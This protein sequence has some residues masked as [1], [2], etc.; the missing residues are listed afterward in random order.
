MPN[1]L[2]IESFGLTFVGESVLYALLLACLVGGCVCIGCAW[3]LRICAESL[4][5][6]L[7]LV[8]ML[9]V[10]RALFVLHSDFQ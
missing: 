8:H 3:A 5:R 1:P 6:D 10:D 2:Y 9:G 7:L 4:I